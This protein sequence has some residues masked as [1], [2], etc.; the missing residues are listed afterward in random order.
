M[1]VPL[2]VPLVLGTV[3]WINGW[4][5]RMAWDHFQ[6]LRQMREELDEEVRERR[7]SDSFDR[8]ESEL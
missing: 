8:W 3:S 5:G 6:Y 1:T 2:W 7:E 4:L